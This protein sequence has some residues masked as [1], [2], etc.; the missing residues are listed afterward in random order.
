MKKI[1]TRIMALLCLSGLAGCKNGVEKEYNMD[2]KEAPIVARLKEDEK[3][4]VL[5]AHCKRGMSAFNYYIELPEME[6]DFEM[7]KQLVAKNTRE[8][9]KRIIIVDGKSKTVSDHGYKFV[10]WVEE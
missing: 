10:K 2:I 4:E 9:I 5:V 7:P 3:K 1:L 6:E 8:T